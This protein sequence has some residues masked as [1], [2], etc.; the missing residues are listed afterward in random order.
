M[1]FPTRGRRQRLNAFTLIELLVVISIISLLMS[2]L[3]PSMSRARAQ[4]KRVH[5]LAKLKDIGNA[6]ATYENVS[7]DF[8]PP[9]SWFPTLEDVDP[10]ADQEKPVEY[11]WTEALFSFLYRERVRVAEDFPV[12]RNTDEDRWEKYFVCKSATVDGINSGHYRVYLPSWSAGT[13]SLG[14]QNRWVE[15][16]RAVPTASAH[17][18]SIRPKLPLLGDANENSERGDGFGTDDCSYIGGGEANIAGST[19]RNGNRFSDRHDG[20][21]NYLFQ[22]LHAEWS[23]KLREQLARDFDLN[24]VVDIEILP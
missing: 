15:E 1:V 14:A 17:R 20:G 7:A 6:L 10:R 11:G 2:I 23:V 22:D 4:A 19:G 18:E 9:A 21:T 16:T 3:L 5:C 12:Q 8:L 24:G 13:Y